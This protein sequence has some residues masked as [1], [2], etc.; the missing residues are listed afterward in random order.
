MIVWRDTTALIALVLVPAVALFFVWA[1]R[2]RER[3][4]ATFVEAALLPAV[5]PDLD[6]R[7]RTARAAMVVAATLC[8]V[9]ALAGPMWG[10]RW[11]EV[12]R[13]GIDLV[14]ALDTSRSM[15]ATDVRPTRLAR[16][17]LAVQDV[18]AQLHG[19]RIALVPFAGSAFVQCPLTLDYGAFA[20]SLDAVEVGIIPK[21]GTSLAAAI[22]TGL[23]AFEG[24]QGNHQALLLITDGEDHDGKVKD[25]TKRAAD[26][27]VKVYTVGIGTAEGE[28]IPLESGGYVKDR[29]GQVVKSRLDEESLKQIAVDTGGVYLHA[30]GPS[31]GLAELYRDYIASIEKRELESTLE[32]RYEHRFQIPLLAAFVL[33]VIEPLIGER[34]VATVRAR[35]LPWRRRTSTAVVVLL[36]ISQLA[37]LDPFA[38]A[39]QGNRLYHEGKYD[40]AA[41][42]Y[43]EALVDHSDSP[44]LHFNLGDATY[45]QG[46]FT[47][48]V[49]AFQQVPATDAEPA[50][51]AHVAYNVGN[52]KYRLGEA[53]EKSDTKAALGLY[54]ESLA[55]YRRSL[56]AAPDDMDAKVNYEL[57][58]K[59]IEDLKKKL[60]EQ[61]KKQDE[62]K[63]QNDQ[64]DQQQQGDQQQQQQDQGKDQQDQKKDESAEQEQQKEP[65]E[66][67]KEQAQQQPGEQQPQGG[68]AEQQ[69]EAA[70]K[71]D[72]EMSQQEAA[73]VLD[74]Q[75]DQEVRP[76]EVV[77]K[78]QGARVAEPAQDW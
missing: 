25:A 6:R 61:Q 42:R 55:A 78:L 49:N 29:S 50:R 43:N 54:A 41:A 20:E 18:L 24:R 22:D 44:L 66:Q 39:R 19:D 73:A 60:E 21:G 57:V 40:D 23:D 48:A 34:R 33:L 12:K 11:Q 3:A 69:A 65:Q 5:A 26:R 13:E 2:R 28:L 31:L 64:Q 10:F 8:L 56:G 71:K 70:E 1:R 58:S 52:A 62:Q 47:D 36:A 4:L 53:A 27:G 59:K 77:K 45:K 15:L 51:T 46:K 67:P 68:G 76:D 63:Q 32:R 38:S 75:R 74:S 17:K 37:W 30:A 72:G 14:V 16:A 9:V 7:R 35:R